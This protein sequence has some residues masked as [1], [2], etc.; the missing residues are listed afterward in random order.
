MQLWLL[1][2]LLGISYFPFFFL[3]VETKNKRIKFSANRWSGWETFLFFLASRAPLQRYA[4]F[5]R[6]LYRNFLTFYS[7]S[8]RGVVHWISHGVIHWRKL[9][10][11][12][13]LQ[14]NNYM[15]YVLLTSHKKDAPFWI[16]K[17]KLIS[18]W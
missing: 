3:S 8:L 16:K 5:N 1:Q 11:K 13:G 17:D 4:E 10:F 18:G 9:N 6:L 7:Y 2:Y 15:L 14:V 12:Q